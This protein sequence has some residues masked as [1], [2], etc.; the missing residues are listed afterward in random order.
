MQ[1]VILVTANGDTAHGKAPMHGARANPVD[2]STN[3]MTYAP[4][5]ASRQERT[6]ARV[7]RPQASSAARVGEAKVKGDK[8]FPM[9][10]RAVPCEWSRARNER[11][12]G[13]GAAA[14]IAK[15]PVLRV[16]ALYYLP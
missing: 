11:V 9:V 15:A 13:T 8:D 6:L 12:T 16:Q 3:R 4:E 14:K 1:S 2:Y 7:V 5:H 10:A